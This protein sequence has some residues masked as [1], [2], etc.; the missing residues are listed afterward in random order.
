MTTY[1]RTTDNEQREL[2]VQKQTQGVTDGQGS[3]DQ[4]RDKVPMPTIR[5]RGCATVEG[6]DSE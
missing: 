4:I 5:E 3:V 6:G 1:T 2:R